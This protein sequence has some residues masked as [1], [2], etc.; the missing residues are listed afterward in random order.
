MKEEELMIPPGSVK[1]KLDRMVGSIPPDKSCELLDGE[2]TH[3][4]WDENDSKDL[5]DR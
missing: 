3:E 1:Q 2:F 5:A 4:L